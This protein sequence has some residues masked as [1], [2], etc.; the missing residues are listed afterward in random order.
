MKIN[1]LKLDEV[2][3]NPGAFAQAIE[4]GGAKGV[5]VGYE[6]EVCVPKATIK[7]YK[8]EEK[9]DY[10]E[11]ISQSLND[12]EAYFIDMFDDPDMFKKLAKYLIPKPEFGY[13]SMSTAYK[14]FKVER[15][16][17]AKE[18]FKLIPAE[19]IKAYR[20]RYDFL[21]TVY[22]KSYS[23]FLRY[24]YSWVD[25]YRKSNKKLWKLAKEIGKTTGMPSA[26]EFFGFI[27]KDDEIIKSS[28]NVAYAVVQ[29]LSRYFDYSA[30]DLWKK[31]INPRYG[32][33]DDDYDY[34]EYDYRGAS[35]VLAPALE[36]TFGVKVNVFDE[37]HQSRKNLTDWY[38]EPDGS[39]EPKDGKD[40]A[41]EVV[42]PPLNAVKAIEALK[43]FYGIAKDLKL[44]TN[45]STGIHINVSIP[46]KIDV[47]KLA[48]FLGDQYVLKAFGRENNNYARSAI[49]HLQKGISYDSEKV[50]KQKKIAKKGG[51]VTGLDFKMLAQ[52]AKDATDDHEASISNNGKY[53]SF[54]HA[55]GDYLAD[56]SKIAHTVGRFIRAMVIAADSEAY[57]KEYL[58]KLTKLI[59]DTAYAKADPKKTTEASAYKARVVDKIKKEGLKALKVHVWNRKTMSADASVNAIIST[60]GEELTG[61][62]IKTFVPLKVIKSSAEARQHLLRIDGRHHSG[63]FK[64]V[65]K[66]SA[67]N[68]FTTVILIPD[69]LRPK[70][71]I[72]F[73]YSSYGLTSINWNDYGRHVGATVE[74]ITYPFTSPEAMNEYKKAAKTYIAMVKKEMKAVKK[75]KKK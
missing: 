24:F 37:Y 40:G 58:T 28:G 30:E 43:G 25:D 44:Y 22:G 5:L 49:K 74:V 20:N 46:E 16:A 60:V 17:K 55:G 59:P 14:K 18:L 47:L 70:M 75:A 36:R 71:G 11:K 73:D 27:F 57:K 64:D 26:D 42:T 38:V 63:T 48:I 29:N 41:A 15:E 50:L 32:D 61:P 51:T 4:E 54:R 21:D 23:L 72:D 1:E 8:R 10:E 62:P 3:M 65:I 2:A 31:F 19:E 45:K 34:Y 66:K 53:I 12:V 13:D 7:A 69:V 67:N 39:L 9:V 35:N 33:D 68:K 6:F 52:L 56:Y